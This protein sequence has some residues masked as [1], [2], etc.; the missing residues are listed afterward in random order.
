MYLLCKFAKYY[1]TKKGNIR[2]EYL[3]V[4]IEYV[5]SD[6]NVI[7]ALFTIDA[8]EMTYSFSLKSNQLSFVK[9]SNSNVLMLQ[10]L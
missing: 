2:N 6:L 5:I 4:K 1:C 7:V 10:L 3:S 8:N 9:T